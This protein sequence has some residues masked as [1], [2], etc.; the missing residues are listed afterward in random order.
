MNGKG[1]IGG[2]IAILILGVMSG[3][4]S[5]EDTNKD[6]LDYDAISTYEWNH[7]NDWNGYKGSRRNSIGEDDALK[8]DG[9]DP[10]EYRSSHGY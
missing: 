3:A 6:F 9:I 4:V 2:I 1:L 10:D 8:S 7:R 5:C